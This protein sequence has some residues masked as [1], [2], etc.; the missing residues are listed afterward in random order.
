MI[1]AVAGQDGDRA[2]AAVDQRL[3][4]APRR[5][6]RFREGHRSPAFPL[7]F[8]EIDLVGRDARPMVE[9]VDHRVRMGRERIGRT[10]DHRPVDETAIAAA[11]EREAQLTKPVFPVER[12]KRRLVSEPLIATPELYAVH[13]SLD[14]FHCHRLCVDELRESCFGPGRSH[15]L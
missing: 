2:E 11:R 6:A 15:K 5:L 7:S 13:F 8:G 12:R 3:G 4:D 10:D 14:F 9:P 1:D